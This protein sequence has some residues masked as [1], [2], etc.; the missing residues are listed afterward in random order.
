MHDILIVGGGPA[1]LTAA[2]YARRAAKRVLI[3][4]K[5]AFG[6]QMTYSPKVE[7]YPGIKSASGNEIADQMLEQ[8]TALGAEIEVDTVTGVDFNPDG[9]KTV[10]GESG[11]YRARAV[12]IAAGCRH[13]RMEVDR[14]EDFVGRGISYC[15]VCDGAFYAGRRVAVIGGGNSALQ[16]ALMLS[17][18]CERVTVVQKLKTLTGE[19]KLISQMGDRPNIEIMYGYVVGGIISGDTFEGVVLRD[20]RGGQVELRVDGV[21][22][23]IGL[24]PENEAYK[25]VAELDE[26]GYFDSDE[27]CETKTA[28]VFVAGDCR[29]KRVRQI[30]TA[31]ADGTVAAL[32]AC[33]Y[34]DE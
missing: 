16:T 30:T 34:L 15:A 18:S 6:G 7:N 29:K 5:A 20:E 28:G 3:I 13:R 25:N 26:E 19:E 4:E 32:A 11:E 27:G 17:E 31:I 14:E 24:V 8:A 9:T 1:G 21:F 2:I 23:S 22:V 12:I 33:R 10:V